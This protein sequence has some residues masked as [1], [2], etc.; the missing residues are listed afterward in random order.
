MSHPD[1]PII[2]FLSFLLLMYCI[3]L[4]DLRILNHLCSLGTNPTQLWDIFT[5][6]ISSFWIVPFTVIDCP[7]LSLVMYF[8]KCIFFWYKY[9]YSS[10]LLTFICVMFLYPHYHSWGVKWVTCRHLNL[11]CFLIHSYSLHL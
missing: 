3:T 2:W 9:C 8:F 4:I 5:V 10:F 7:P 11:F 1:A 6:V